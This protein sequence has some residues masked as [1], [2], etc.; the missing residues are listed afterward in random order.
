[1][2]YIYHD[3]SCIRLIDLSSYYALHSIPTPIQTSQPIM[4][5]TMGTL[6]QIMTLIVTILASAAASL[7]TMHFWSY[8]TMCSEEYFS[9]HTRLHIIIYYGFLSLTLCLLFLHACSSAVRSFVGFQLL[10][11]VPLL[12]QRLTLDGLF[13]CI[14]ISVLAFGPVI[15]WFPTQLEFWGDRADPLS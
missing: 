4:H 12:G 7:V 11:N 6:L 8:A 13:T 9:Y 10:A 5:S 2:L 14:W 1:M 15:Y 3:R